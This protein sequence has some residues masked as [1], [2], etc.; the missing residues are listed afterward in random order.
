MCTMRTLHL[1]CPA[2]TAKL[3]SSSLAR[4]HRGPLRRSAMTASDS[5]S[6]HSGWGRWLSSISVATWS[7]S[8]CNLAAVFLVTI[9][10]H[11]INSPAVRLSVLWCWRRNGG[12]WQIL[13]FTYH[14][15]ACLPPPTY[16][17][18]T[19][20]LLRLCQCY[21]M[22][23][24]TEN[25]EDTPPNKPLLAAGKH[26]PDW[27]IFFHVHNSQYTHNRI[28]TIAVSQNRINGV[29]EL[30]CAQFI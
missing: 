2:I 11:S 13:H 4:S 29:Q 25:T 1:L 5:V 12:Y 21:T 27:L 7:W 26:C 15:N 6:P 30:L 24:V 9:M 8:S 17:S 20:N 19:A 10:V 28:S 18:N 22:W 14:N 3:K 23:K 16:R